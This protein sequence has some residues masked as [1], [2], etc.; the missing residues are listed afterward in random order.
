MFENRAGNPVKN[1]VGNPCWEPWDSC[2]EPCRE[3]CWE[4]CWELCLEP[5]WEPYWEPVVGNPV[6]GNPVVG[7]PFGN[8]GFPQEPCREPVGNPVG[9]CDPIGNLL[10]G[11][12]LLG[13]LLGTLFGTLLGTLFWEPCFGKSVLGTLLLGT[14]LW[15]PCCWEPCWE[16]CFQNPVWGTLLLGTQL[17]TLLGTGGNPAEGWPVLPLWLKTPSFQLLGKKHYT[18]NDKRPPFSRPDVFDPPPVLET[19]KVPYLLQ[20]LR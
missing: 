4:S 1:F 3:P 17:G 11:T 13:T 20:S 7:N 15:E 6:V 2:Q 14:L 16:P 5:C 18:L 12:L 19:P 8:S 10:L 9:N